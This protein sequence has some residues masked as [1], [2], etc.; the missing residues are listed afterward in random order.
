L[1]RGRAGTL[2]LEQTAAL[3]VD[4]AAAA[5]VEAGLF[6]NRFEGLVDECGALLQRVALSVNVKERLDFSC[7]LLDPAGRLAVNAPH[8]PVHLGALGVCVRELVAALA[9]GP[10]DVVAV[11]HPAFGGSHLPDVTVLAGAFDERGQLLGWLANRAHHAEIGG[12]APGSMPADARCLAEEGVVI[13]PLR[14]VRGG[15]ACFEEV[16]RVLREAPWPTRRL[17]DNLADLEAQVAAASHGVR[18]L[19]ALAARHGAESVRHHLAAIPQESARRMSWRIAGREGWSGSAATHLDDGTPLA[20]RVAVEHG[21]M[22]VDF[23]GSGGVHPRNLNATP[24]IVRSV[25]LYVLRV[26]LDDDVPLNEGLLE[27][28]DLRI[29][30]GLLNPG[31]DADPQRCPAV[32]GGNVEISQRLADILFDALGVCANGP[33]TMNNFLF[34]DDSFGYYETLAGGGPAGPGFAGRSGRHCH[35]TNTAITDPEVLESRLPVRLRRF[36]LYRGSGGAGRWPGGDGVIRE[37]EF[38]RPLTVSF[39]CERR[40]AGPSGRAGGGDGI[41]GAQWRIHP[42]G[43]QQSLPGAVTYQ[44]RTGERVRIETPGGGAWG[45]P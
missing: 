38:L 30:T 3:R 16:T 8:V 13:P 17:A 40:T 34:G 7:A 41:P 26:W 14:L 23:A 39:L 29:P 44:A 24:A 18:L 9:P 22:S 35:M 20:V 42:D 36:A 19:E 31:F 6:R 45:A 25:L 4:P 12:R 21:R 10:G 1:R 43:R 15:T 32:V 27:A 5:A 2:L 37:I 28:V 33:G 11:N